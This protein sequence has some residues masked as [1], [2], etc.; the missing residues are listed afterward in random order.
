MYGM[1][2]RKVS[3]YYYVREATAEQPTGHYCV[4]Y[5]TWGFDPLKSDQQM[6]QRGQ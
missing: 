4:S 2:E 6:L 5:S 1:Y 3:L